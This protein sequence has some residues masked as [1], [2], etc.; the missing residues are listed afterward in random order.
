MRNVKLAK[1]K[2]NL[3]KFSIRDNGFKC[4]A[5][6][7]QDK[8]AIDMSET[9]KD[10]IRYIILSDAKKIYSF[11][12]PKESIEELKNNIKIIFN[13]KTRKRV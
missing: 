3:T 10:A 12:V 4:T 11:Q 13:R 8:G 6:G 9:T 1:K 2:K 5:C 7:K